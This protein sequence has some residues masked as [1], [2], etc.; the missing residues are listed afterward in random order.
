MKTINLKDKKAQAALE[1]LVT[2]GW[3]ILIILVVGLVLWQMGIFNRISTP[4]NCVG[5]S[6]ITPL[7]WKAS[8][9]ELTLL[10]T[11]EAG[12]KLNLTGVSASVFGTPCNT[13]STT[14][15][16]RPGQSRMV[17]LSGCGGLPNTGEYYRANITIVYRHTTSGITHNSIGTCWGDVE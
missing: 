6:Q 13:N 4:P 16:L 8:G 15:D 11:N 1:Y 14:A 17:V 12:T 2:Y 5:F 7:D 3:A 10:L 9:N